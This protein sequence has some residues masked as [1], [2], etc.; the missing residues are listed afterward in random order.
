MSIPETTFQGPTWF[1]QN[2]TFIMGDESVEPV[3]VSGEEL[4]PTADGLFVHPESDDWKRSEVIVSDPGVLV[5]V[6]APGTGRGTAALRRLR[7]Q[8][9]TNR[10]VRLQTNWEQPR[11]QLLPAAAQGHGYV[12]DMSEYD[13]CPSADF[14]AELL[15]WAVD[16]GAR[17]VVLTCEAKVKEQWLGKLGARIV[18]L[19]TP[20]GKELAESILQRTGAGHLS[21][22]LVD[23]ALVE[24]WESSPRA[25]EVLR[26][27]DILRTAKPDTPGKQIAEEF[28]GWRDWFKTVC[29]SDLGARTLLWSAAMCDGGRRDSVLAM[30]EAF[31][32]EIGQTRSLVDIF[33]DAFTSERLDSAELVEVDG[34]VR[35]DP[36]SHGLAAAVRLHLW[37]Q[38]PN[39]RKTLRTW[40][41]DIVQKLDADDARRVV[42]SLMELAVRLNDRSLV[43]ELFEQL[44]GKRPELLVEEL[45]KASLD[46]VLGAYVRGRLY[47]WLA[48]KPSQ[49]KVDVV[50]AVCGGQFGMAS[51]NLA[52]TR[53]GRAALKSPDPVSPALVDAFTALGASK[54][55]ALVLTTIRKWL[56]KVELERAG[57]VAFLCLANSGQGLVVLCGEGGRDLESPERLA[58]LADAFRKAHNRAETRTAAIG[59]ALFWR[60]AVKQALIPKEPVD[61]LFTTVIKQDMN[62]DFL[63]ALTKNDPDQTDRFGDT[64]LRRLIW[65]PKHSAEAPAATDLSNS[66][67]SLLGRE[68]GFVAEEA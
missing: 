10:V 44:S 17:L 12:L 24:I 32:Q 29:P 35:V 50:A 51:P 63:E 68:E 28:R 21:F 60:E 25:R 16:G 45:M 43:Q 66:A 40:A 38:F 26:L 23:E 47:T 31:R 64:M 39:Q 58:T 33:S 3:P 20:P 59:A 48:A 1:G 11:K 54:H 49:E 61:E 42:S 18:R 37:N 34:G 41:L 52:L 55:R 62:L 5:I 36:Q 65:G 56:G 7:E 13:K 4:R 22:R 46:P 8:C 67:E 27:T 57:I 53:L 9:G 6:G 14:G 19:A 15:S 30:S 2:M